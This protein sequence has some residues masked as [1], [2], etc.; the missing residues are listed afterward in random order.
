MDRP[1]KMGSVPRLAEPITFF[2]TMP[3]CLQLCIYLL[4]ILHI[5]RHTH[6]SLF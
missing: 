3:A 1:A 4:N 2:L 6:F 5:C